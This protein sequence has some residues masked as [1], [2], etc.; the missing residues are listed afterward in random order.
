MKRR[1]IIVGGASTLALGA[2]V[3]SFASCAS[4]EE[5]GP[6]PSSPP[7]TVPEAAPPVDLD[8]G[9]ADAGCDAGDPSCTTEVVSCDSVSWCAVP[10]NVSPF[11]A[12]TAIWG[13][14][15]DDVWAV[16][17]GGTIIHYDGKS[18][19]NT[20]TGVQNTFYGIW[21][22]GPNDVWAVSST[23]VVLHSTGFQSDGGGGWQNVPTPNPRYNSA[24]VRAVW[25]SSPTDVRIGGRAFD[26]PIRDEQDPWNAG[27]Q[28]LRTVGE[29]GTVV[30]APLRGTHTVTS[31]WGS[32]ATDVWMTAD[33]SVYVNYQRGLILHGTP[34]D[35]GANPD[36]NVAEDHL[37]WTPVDSQSSLTLNSVWGSS[38]SDVWAVGALGTIRHITPSD[39]RWQEVTSPTTRDLHTVWGT[40]SNDVWVVG[41]AGT[42]LHF[43]GTAFTPVAAQL[44]LGRKPDLHGVWGSS[45]NDVW[46]VGDGIVLHYTGPKSGGIK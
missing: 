26:Y 46:I 23:E 19:T 16:G 27:D 24:F 31:I 42:I 30:W 20:P 43:D 8:A 36:A 17:S 22:S 14:S 40:A 2:L 39:V 38:A 33:N 45:A 32:S 7:A 37:K 29:D 35:A 15:K 1:S 5:A 3:A 28:F 44:P 41:D 25:G 9:P 11:F 21:G 13:S 10:T 4:N 34:S 18:W 12:L 6:P